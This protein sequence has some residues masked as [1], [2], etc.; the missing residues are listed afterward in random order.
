LVNAQKLASFSVTNQAIE[1]N[2]MIELI[3]LYL[4]D[5]GERAF[6]IDWRPENFSYQ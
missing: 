1:N 4:K 5:N 3:T 6:K 2:S